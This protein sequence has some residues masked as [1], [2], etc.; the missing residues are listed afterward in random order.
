MNSTTY[1]GYV[2]FFDLDEYAYFIQG[3]PT[4]YHDISSV[5]IGIDMLC[6]LASC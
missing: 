6:L 4:A 3:M 1:R 2:Y 5:K